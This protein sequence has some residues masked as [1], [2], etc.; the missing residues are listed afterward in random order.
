MPYHRA[1]FARMAAARMQSTGNTV[2]APTRTMAA[3]PKAPPLLPTEA[4]AIQ[5]RLEGYCPTWGGRPI[6]RW[7]RWGYWSPNGRTMTVTR[8]M[9]AK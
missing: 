1:T 9:E 6:S 7:C 4:L 2:T 8:I 3:I 5:A